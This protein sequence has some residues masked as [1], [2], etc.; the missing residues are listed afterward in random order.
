VSD[1]TTAPAVD[2]HASLWAALHAFQ[3]EAPTLPKDATNPHFKSKFTPLDTIVEVIQPLLTK[4]GLV[5]TAKPG[6]SVSDGKPCLRYR[7]THASSGEF[8]EDEMDLLLAKSDPQGQGS[9][10]TYA[11][12]YAIC[13]V[14]NLVADEDDDGHRPTAANREEA[15]AR[16]ALRNTI[17]ESGLIPETIKIL[18]ADAGAEIP[19]GSTVNVTIDSLSKD[20]ALAVVAKIREELARPENVS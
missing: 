11:R 20:Q 5:W 19:Y 9:A 1:E 2:G 13:A 4:H 18:F 12:R 7:I 10:L 3:A 6:R 14:L 16:K 8:T 17:R 15:E